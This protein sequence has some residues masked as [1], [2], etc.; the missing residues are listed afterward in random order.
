MT[1]NSDSR[2]GGGRQPIRLVFTRFSK[3]PPLHLVPTG[4][5]KEGYG[6]LLRPPVSA[7]EVLPPG[8]RW[9]QQG[10]G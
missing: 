3:R 2:D 6:H 5:S 1:K 7:W 8:F 10:G 4:F 9:I